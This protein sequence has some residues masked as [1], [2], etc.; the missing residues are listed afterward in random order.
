MEIV[1]GAP[2]AEGLAEMSGLGAAIRAPA[3]LG[4]IGAD[5]DIALGDR[6]EQRDFGD[7]LVLI[8]FGLARV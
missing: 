7:G 3:G 5:D 1:G 8:E 4:Q 6:L 2:T